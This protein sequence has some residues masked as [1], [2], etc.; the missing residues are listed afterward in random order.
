L[1]SPEVTTILGEELLHR[2]I[3]NIERLQQGRLEY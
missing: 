1:H 3:E 2:N